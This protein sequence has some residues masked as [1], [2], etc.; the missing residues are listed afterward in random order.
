VPA[1]FALVVAGALLYRN[2]DD[3]QS[4]RLGAEL[5]RVGVMAVLESVC[6]LAPSHPFAQA[7]AARY[8]AFIITANETIFPPVHTRPAVSAWRREPAA[9]LVQARAR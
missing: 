7:V 6:G 8:R 9:I 4:C 2:Q 3:E 1:Y 5:E